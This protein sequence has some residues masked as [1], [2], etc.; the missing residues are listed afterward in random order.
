MFH[1][2]QIRYI[3]KPHL[4]IMF[5]FFFI[6]ILGPKIILRNLYKI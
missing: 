3:T 6:Y 1:L 5:D 4:F 2:A